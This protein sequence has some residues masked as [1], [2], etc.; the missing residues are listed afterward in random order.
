MKV[1]EQID[2]LRAL[3]VQPIS[4]LV[5]PRVLAM[6]LS[7]PLLVAECVGFGILAGYLVGTQGAGDFGHLLHELHAAFHRSA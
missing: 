6:L 2:A 7:M 3:G 1:T 4:Y 5:V